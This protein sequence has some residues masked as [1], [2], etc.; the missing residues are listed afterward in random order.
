MQPSIPLTAAQYETLY[1][2][3]PFSYEKEAPHIYYIITNVMLC[4][5]FFIWLSPFCG[6]KNPQKNGENQIFHCLQQVER[7]I[8]PEFF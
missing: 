3:A 2:A 1:I 4:Q 5:A 6:E 8:Y 7:T